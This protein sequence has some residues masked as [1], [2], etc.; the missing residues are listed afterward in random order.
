MET[1]IDMIFKARHDSEIDEIEY[2]FIVEDS[3][4]VKVPTEFLFEFNRK[5]NSP[6]ISDKLQALMSIAE[7]LNQ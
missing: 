5:L 7:F 3:D 4:M 6:V 1:V 2:I